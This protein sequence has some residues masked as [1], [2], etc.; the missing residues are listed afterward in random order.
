LTTSFSFNAITRLFA[1]D[2][3]TLGDFLP[4]FKIKVSKKRTFIDRELEKNDVDQYHWYQST[5]CKPLVPLLACSLA[6]GQLC[7]YPGNT[8][9]LVLRCQAQTDIVLYN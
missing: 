7:K 6:T 4:Y 9:T 3:N 1:P 2:D 8:S 5:S